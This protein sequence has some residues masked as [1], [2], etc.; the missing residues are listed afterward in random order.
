MRA[1]PSSYS[2]SIAGLCVAVH[3]KSKKIRCAIDAA[4]KPASPARKGSFFGCP[5][6]LTALSHAAI[7]SPPA[8]D[9]STHLSQH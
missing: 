3:K 2:V 8:I 5:C 7:L 6:P 4:Q 9:A 1:M